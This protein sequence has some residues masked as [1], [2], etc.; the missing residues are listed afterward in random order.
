MKPLRGSGGMVDTQDLKSCGG[1]SV[2]VQV[3]P[4][5]PYGWI[6]QLVEHETE[7]LGVPG[8]IPGPATI[9]DFY[10][11]LYYNIYVIK[12]KCSLKIKLFVV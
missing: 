4:P 11:K 10:K 9:F 1:N 12:N 7:N 2:R 3:P 6:A 5:P 8:S